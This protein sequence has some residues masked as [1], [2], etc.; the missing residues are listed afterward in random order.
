MSGLVTFDG[1]K[2]Y[3]NIGFKV[4]HCKSAILLVLLGLTSF[5]LYI[6]FTPLFN[7]TIHNLSSGVCLGSFSDLVF[8]ASRAVHYNDQ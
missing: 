3:R 2:V 8:Y 6:S 7:W 1:L 5:L 4:H